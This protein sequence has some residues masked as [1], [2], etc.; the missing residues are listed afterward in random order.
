ML[1]TIRKVTTAVAAAV[2]AL[3]I[4]PVQAAPSAE[5][6]AKRTVCVW[7]IVGRNGPIALAVEEFRLEALKWNIDFNIEVNSSE[8]VVVE[9]FRAKKCDAAFMSE[10]RVRNFVKFSGSL[11]AVGALPEEKHLRLMYQ[12]LA[13]PQMA[14]KLQEGPFEIAGIAPAGMVYV[15]VRDRSINSL[16]KA[17]GRKIAVLGDDVYQHQ[18]VELIGGTPVTVTEASAGSMF[19]NGAVDVMPAPA[20]AYNPL[21]L[22][23]GLEPDGGIINYP[24]AQISGQLI[25]W[26]DRFPTDFAQKSREFHYSN[27]DR[28]MKE[29]ELANEAIDPKWW[30][31]IPEEDKANYEKLMDDVR[32]EAVKAGYW[33]GEM[34]KLQRRIRCKFDASRAECAKPRDAL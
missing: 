28:I 16:D 15:F 33:D 4:T 22:Y 32:I 13:S 12:L 24:L 23:K 8:R 11:Y 7:D 5:T 31:D 9:Q 25:I 17:V 1:N 20:V 10:L 27:F 18:M 2:M 21:E 14:D 3:A 26:Q 19:N 34:I 30:V 6:P 29:I